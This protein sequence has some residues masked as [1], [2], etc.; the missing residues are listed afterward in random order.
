MPMPDCMSSRTRFLTALVCGQPDRVPM[1]D[2]LFSRALYDHILGTRNSDNTPENGVRVARTLGTD[3][4][5]VNPKGLPPAQEG[6]ALPPGVTRNEWGTMYKRLDDTWCSTGPVAW[7]LK[8]RSD[9]CNYR[10]PDPNDPR[11]MEPVREAV[12]LTRDG[13][14]AIMGAVGGPLTAAYEGLFNPQDF[15]T[16]LHDDPELIDEVMSAL[17]D[18]NLRIGLHL[19]EAGVDCLCIPDDMG[20]VNGPLMSPRMFRRFVL[21][22]FR[23]LA[24]GLRQTGLPILMHNDGDL[25]LLLDDLVDTGINGYHPVERAAR[26][27]L[28]ECKR[29]YAGRLCLVGNVDNKYLMVNGTPEEIEAQVKE[30][31][32]IA[33]PGGGYVLAS[34]H[35]LHDDQPIANIFA[36]FEAGKRYGDYAARSWC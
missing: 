3:C 20:F 25:R 33:A 19:V 12:K 23:R 4:L 31:L 15:F 30:C 35:S 9:W 6:A 1:F 27:D 17:T 5:C 13:S 7:P 32:R 11:R 34:D 14:L 22:H 2:F 21:P 26:M 29:R 28:A 10:L 18:Y 8:D 16:L 36:L 24:Q